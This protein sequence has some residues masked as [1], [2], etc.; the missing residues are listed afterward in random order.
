MD[1]KERNWL[2]LPDDIVELTRSHLFLT[3]DHIHF[4]SVFKSWR[5][6]NPLVHLSRR[7]QLLFAHEGDS[8]CK[9]FD[10]SY[11]K[12]YDF[13]ISHLKDTIFHFSTDGP[14]MLSNFIVFYICACDYSVFIYIYRH[15]GKTWTQKEYKS[16][17]HFQVGHNNHVYHDGLFYCLA[18]DERLGVFD[19]SKST[20]TVLDK[21]K[22]VNLERSQAF[23]AENYMV[24]SNGELLLAFTD[25]IKGSIRV[26]QLDRCEKRL[27]EAKDLSNQT[28]FVSQ[29][30]SL[31]VAAMKRGMENMIYFPMYHCD[32]T[33][34]C[35]SYFMKSESGALNFNIQELC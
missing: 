15:N 32:F 35:L 11:N 7:P 34:G 3:R 4:S 25:H 23:T 1:V 6:I 13:S 10:P 29:R 22:G 28:L 18:L 27:V 20:W 8:L 26:F 5:L 33:G 31:S 30:R 16:R 12:I 9:L 21:L 2:E 14:P 24:E 17:L 19:P